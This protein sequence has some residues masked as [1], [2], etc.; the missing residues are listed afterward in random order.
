MRAFVEEAW[1]SMSVIVRHCY[2]AA[3]LFKHL[4]GTVELIC[5]LVVVTV[6]KFPLLMEEQ[7]FASFEFH[8]WDGNSLVPLWP[9]D[10]EQKGQV[11]VHEGDPARV[12]REELAIGKK[13]HDKVFG[14]FL[15]NLDSGI[16]ESI[17]RAVVLRQQT[18]DTN[19]RHFRKCVTV[20]PSTRDAYRG[21]A[22]LNCGESASLAADDL[23][24]DALARTA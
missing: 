17:L 4:S 16:L 20:V 8:K 15:K 24:V 21:G 7:Q 6:L 19:E 12:L 11:S 14:S 22:S 23:T 10:S 18:H 13:L 5:V 9:K 3:N 1:V 2:G